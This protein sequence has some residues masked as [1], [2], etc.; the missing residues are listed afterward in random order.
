[1]LSQSVQ[2]LGGLQSSGRGEG[3]EKAGCVFKICVKNISYL[4]PHIG[5]YAVSVPGPRVGTDSKLAS[6]LGPE[7]F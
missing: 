1:M 3:C 2:L 4:N 5:L 6:A 7:R